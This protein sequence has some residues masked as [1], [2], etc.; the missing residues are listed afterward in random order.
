MQQILN[1]QS[2]KKD[3]P[4]GE[5]ASLPEPKKALAV[6]EKIV[7]K[8]VHKSKQIM[9]HDSIANESELQS[10]LNP[11]E[12]I[13]DVPEV[14]RV[15]PDDFTPLSHLGGGSF[16]DVYLVRENATEEL[17]AMKVLSK[18]KILGQNLVRYAKTE[19]DVLSYTMHSFIVGLNYAF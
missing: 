7:K 19:R 10:I 1:N 3:L 16:G 18:Q 17:F 9:I 13:V 12:S 8:N 6:N 11:H 5:V 15:G 14:R 4:P 2:S